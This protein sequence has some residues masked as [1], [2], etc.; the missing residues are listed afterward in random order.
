MLGILIQFMCLENVSD[1][2]TLWERERERER[3]RET[4]TDRQTD[5]NRDRQESL[6][7]QLPFI[8]IDYFSFSTVHD[9]LA[10]LQIFAVCGNISFFAESVDE[11]NVTNSGF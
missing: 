6:C 1:F 8:H 10:Y 2:K 4:K 7:L 3:E 5:S 11:G 9:L